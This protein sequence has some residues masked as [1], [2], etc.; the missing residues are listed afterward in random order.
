M[1][2]IAN[3]KIGIVVGSTD[4]LPSDIAINVGKK[5]VAD[6]KSAYPDSDIHE[7][8]ICIT[9]NEMSVKR[10]LKDIINAECNA[11][12]IYFANYGPESSGTLLAKKFSGPVLMIGAADEGD[13][14]YIK[15]RK[16][17]ISGFLNAN[18]ALKLRKTRVFIPHNPIG[19]IKECSKMLNDFIPIARTLIS[20]DDLKVITFGPRPSSYLASNAP[21]N[22]IF[23]LGVEVS[24]FSELEL[25][26]AYQKHNDDSRISERANNMKEEMKVQTDSLDNLIKKFAQY[27]LTIEDW[28][29]NYK[30]AS[31]YVTLTSTC[32]PAFP[33]NFGFT[34]CY[35]N[36]RLTGKGIPVACEVDE[37]G[38]LSEYIAQCVSDNVVTIL[39]INNNIPKEL[40]DK[41]IKSKKF[42]DK[43]YQLNDLFLGYH[44]GVANSSLLKAPELNCHFVNNQLIGEEKS[45]GTIH[46]QL[47]ESDVTIF[48]IQGM[49]DGTMRAYVAQGQLLP[50]EMETYGGQ[51]IIAIPEF[52]RLVRN[53]I[54][55][56][57]F[58]NHTVVMF[59]H[60]G[61]QM[62]NL[63]KMMGIENI[64]YNQ[65]KSMLYNNENIFDTIDNW[66]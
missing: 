6:Y 59:G 10:A 2:N 33:V 34:P 29:R 16:D 31:K 28:I 66:Y 13:G 40:F 61:S 48:R 30:G 50:V 22:R 46:G 11:L 12:C 52:G 17:S 35:V 60:Y 55:E 49:N 62:I 58:P 65:P 3:V 20:L 64:Y 57:G 63:F 37:Y 24:E 9:D 42:N 26:N 44:C 19:T 7:C 5:F 23:D 53:V 4:W 8:P 38:A 45:Q 39:N 51:G 56:H 1:N 18:F 21:N 15:E 25:Y 41:K 36:S 32:W 27:E 54:I 47:R 14:P 43:E